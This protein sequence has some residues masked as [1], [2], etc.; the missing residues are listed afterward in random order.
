MRLFN[1]NEKLINKN[2]SKYLIDW[3]KKSRSLPQWKT[4]Q[5]LKP[6]WGGHICYEEFPVFGSLLKL[7]IYN[8]TIKVGIEIQGPQHYVFNKHF[9]GNSPSNYLKQIKNDARKEQWCRLNN[10]RLIE[11]RD[12]EVGQLS[13]E[14]LKTNFDLIL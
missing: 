3:D 6:Y 11:L 9:H 4:K 2:V 10:I 8:A 13:P 14:F 7:D 12:L 1:I 5:F